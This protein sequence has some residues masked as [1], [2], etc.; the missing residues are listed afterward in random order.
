MQDD[1]PRIE[2][3]MQEKLLDLAVRRMRVAGYS[4]FSFREL[5]AEAGIK[6]ASVHYHFPTK[7]TMAVMAVRRYS[8]RFL[9]TTASQLKVSDQRVEEVYREAF[10]REASENGGMCL[11]GV[12][13]AEAKGLPADVA[14]EVQDF[15]RRCIEDLAA[16]LNGTDSIP[17]AIRI[18]AALEGGLLVARAFRDMSAYDRA[19]KDIDRVK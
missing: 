13:A 1:H 11:C 19:T 8:D 15:F 6:S 12:L 18:L 3:E 5:A 2:S 14:G 17:R 4:G 10:R 7:A 9:E 16:H